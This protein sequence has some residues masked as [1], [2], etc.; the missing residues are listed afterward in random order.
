MKRIALWGVCV[1]GAIGMGVAASTDEGSQYSAAAGRAVS[2]LWANIEANPFP[3]LIALGTF[4][5]TVLYHKARGKSLR[6]SVEVAATRVTLVPVPAAN[7]GSED[8]NPVLRRARARTT[9]A[10]LL[11]DQ[12]TLQ[13][14]QRKLPEE[15]AKAEKETCYTEQAL[16]DARRLLAAKQ[17]AHEE[18]V[19]KLEAVR[20][21]YAECEGELAAIED[22]LKKLVELI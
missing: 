13:N 8:D 9:R 1:A 19:Q 17:K 6:E 4:L 12:I 16:A 7:R 10:Q 21:E 3:V 2:K 22:E 20:K 15:V 14:R 11:V 5:L 18:A